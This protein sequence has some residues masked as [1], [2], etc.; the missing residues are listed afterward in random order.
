MIPDLLG[1]RVARGTVV[2]IV[3][4]G[5]GV[6]VERLLAQL[7]E[8]PAG[9]LAAVVLTV[10]SPEL[11]ASLLSRASFFC[12]PLA[13][14]LNLHVLQNANPLGFGANHN[15]A[16]RVASE[17]FQDRLGIFCA[18]NPDIELMDVV[19]HT[20]AALSPPLLLKLVDALVQPGVGM[21]YPAQVDATGRLLDFER[22]LATPWGIASRVGGRVVERLVGQVWQRFNGQP[23]SAGQPPDW[24][25]GA[26]MAFRADVFAALGGFD[27]RYFMYCEDIDIC[28]RLQLTGYTL[29]RANVAVVHHTQ[30]RTLKNRQHLAWHIQSLLRLWR[31]SAYHDYS[32]LLKKRKTKGR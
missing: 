10:N 22:V 16:F 11:D 17:L 24:V 2:S 15:R 25:N 20:G 29:A 8:L 13:K 14:A 23:R 4:H 12:G 31:S 32:E 7:G 27:E 9:A 3:S 21:A 30:R 19:R 18:V 28:L 6:Q 26:F 1:T 5:H